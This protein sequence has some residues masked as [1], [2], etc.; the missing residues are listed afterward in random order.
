[1]FSKLGWLLIKAVAVDSLLVGRQRAQHF[2]VDLL[3]GQGQIHL[4]HTQ[5]ALSVDCKFQKM[6]AVD[7]KFFII[8]VVARIMKTL[9]E[10]VGMAFLLISEH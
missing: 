10:E 6:Y 9:R 1:M 5:C 3:L 7:Q 8:T 4:L 2:R